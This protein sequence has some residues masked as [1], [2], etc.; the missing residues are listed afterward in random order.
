M[1]P[2][3]SDQTF[4]EVATLCQTDCS[5]VPHWRILSLSC[6][7]FSLA[8]LESST[9]GHSSF[10]FST[11]QSLLKVAYAF[12][13]LVSIIALS[14]FSLPILSI[15]FYS[16]A[17]SPPA[18]LEPSVLRPDYHLAPFS[19]RHPTPLCFIAQAH[20]QH[21]TAFLPSC[22]MEAHSLPSAPL[23]SC[24]SSWAPLYVMQLCPILNPYP[25]CCTISTSGFVASIFQQFPDNDTGCCCPVL[26]TYI[27]IP[28]PESA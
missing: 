17:F 15:S 3:A 5:L 12:R 26:N 20:C 21:I 1:A 6:S 10:H 19:D 18:V 13:L 25:I 16:P 27:S 28:M 2:H 24:I 8:A 9:R 4:R 22:C 14:P 11:S 7:S 23:C